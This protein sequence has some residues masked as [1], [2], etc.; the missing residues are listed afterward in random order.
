MKEKIVLFGAGKNAEKV[1]SR[2]LQE[3]VAVIDNDSSKVGKLFHKK[4]IISL[5][6]YIEKYRDIPIVITSIYAKDIIE[7]LRK[8]GIFQ[9]KI[10]NV[11]F[12][13]DDVTIADE[14]SHDNWRN[15][16]KLLCDKPGMRVLEIGSRVVTG[17]CLRD[18]FQYAEYTGFDFYQGENVD[19]V[20]DIH[21][22]HTYFDEP[23]DLIFC[24]AVFEHLAMPWKAS[25]EMIKLLKKNGYIFVETHYSY[26]SHERPWH[27]FQF[28]EN[29]L[30]VLFPECFGI[31]C[32]KKGCSNLLEGRFSSE[33]SEYLQGNMVAGLYCHSEFLGQKIEEVSGEK[34]SWDNI[35]LED[36]VGATKYPNIRSER[37]EK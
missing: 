21:K 22:L 35:S 31:K 3:I 30:N 7:Q 11:I 13:A 36:V 4:Y 29:A 25:L 26:S 15:Y 12:E 16:L 34:L 10:S 23:F 9:Y 24:S 14:I 18:L 1:Y 6:D 37:R 17:A 8:S 19:V 5:K 32:V 33:A 2:G 20:G 28:S 27:F